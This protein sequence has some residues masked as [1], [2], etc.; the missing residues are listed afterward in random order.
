MGPLYDT[1]MSHPQWI[2]IACVA[3]IAI[4]VWIMSL[5]G[6][7]IQGEVDVL[8]GVLGIGVAVSVRT[9]MFARSCLIFSL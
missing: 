5:V 9:S 3:W 6:W 2:A 1:V 7:M 8:F 4:A